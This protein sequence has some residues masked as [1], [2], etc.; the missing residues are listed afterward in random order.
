MGRAGPEQVGGHQAWPVV[1]FPPTRSHH[2]R[3]S[4]LVAVLLDK[5][6]PL[7]APVTKPKL[8]SALY[9]VSTSWD[10]EALAPPRS[11]GQGGSPSPI[12]FSGVFLGRPL[13][14]PE[15]GT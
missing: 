13:W 11:W 10:P 2:R 8:D 6:E 5:K 15:L 7:P 1:A 12:L 14:A 9:K 4:A 3:P